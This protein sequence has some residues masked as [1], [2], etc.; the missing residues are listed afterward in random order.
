MTQANLFGLRQ[1]RAVVIANGLMSFGEDVTLGNPVESFLV[2]FAGVR[3]EDDALAWSPAAR[4]HLGMEAGREL[5]LVVVGVE[6]GAQVNIALGP[7]QGAEA[8]FDV[9]GIRVA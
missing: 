8:F 5:F 6:L 1:H 2:G 7:A 4:V 3:L 9:L